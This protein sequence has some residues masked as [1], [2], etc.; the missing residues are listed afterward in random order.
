[1]ID[2]LIHYVLIGNFIIFT[3][4]ST[5]LLNLGWGFPSLIAAVI[6]V[7]NGF[8]AYGFNELVKEWRWL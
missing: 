5:Y 1:V 3:A 4:L 8:A 6:A 2:R 7:L